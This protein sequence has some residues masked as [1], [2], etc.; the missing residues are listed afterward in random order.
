TLSATCAEPV[1]V[2]VAT[3]NGTATAGDDYVALPATTLT[4]TPG[5]IRKTVDVK[6]NGNKIVEPNETFFLNLNQATNATIADD[7]GIATILN[8]DRGTDLTTISVSSTFDAGGEGW[9]THGD[10]KP[11]PLHWYATRGNPGGYLSA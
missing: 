10:S 1:T 7:Q 11:N 6:V 8:D 3:L 9:T 5:E 2:Q 4:F